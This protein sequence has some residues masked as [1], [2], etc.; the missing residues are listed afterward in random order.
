MEPLPRGANFKRAKILW[1][2]G[3]HVAS[4]PDIPYGGNRDMNITV[5]SGSGER[6]T[7]SLRLA[8][9]SAIL[10][11][12][13]VKGELEM[14]FV[15][16]SAMLTQAYRGTGLFHEPLPVRIIGSYPSLD[17]FVITVRATLGFRT[18]ADVKAAHHPL[19]ISI[20]E[21]PTHSTLALIGQLLA[22]YGITL[23]DF[24][25]WGGTIQRVGGPGDKRRLDELRAG[26][27]DL[28]LDE[29]I[30]TWLPTALESGLVP[31][32]IEPEVYAKIGE[33]GW[34]KADL[35]QKRFPLLQRDYDCIDF[36]G[37]P[38]YAS[39]ALPDQVAYDVCEAFAARADEMPWEDGAY[40][41]VSQLFHET[42]A[43]PMDVPLHPGVERWLSDHAGS[44]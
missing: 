9:G 32:E 40:T 44:L 20:R 37:W 15:N 1:E 7:P 35:P 28:V 25:A 36:S 29:G 42:D 5:G 17:R 23:G 38:L 33:L 10:A 43:T 14:A 19:R 21:D 4:R 13:I 18:L 6:F 24:E 26:T 11:H 12:A 22:C 30:R 27:I 16:P 41:G 34:R 31:L 39:A 2:L 3:L 8:T